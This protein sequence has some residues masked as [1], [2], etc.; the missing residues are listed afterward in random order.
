MCTHVYIYSYV[1]VLCSYICMCTC[2]CI[3]CV[4]MHAAMCLTVGMVDWLTITIKLA[5][6]YDTRM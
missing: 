1:H 3:I 6:V 4:S 5:T 2:E